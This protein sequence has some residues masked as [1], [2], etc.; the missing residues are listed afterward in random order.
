MDSSKFDL[1]KLRSLRA[2]NG[3]WCTSAAQQVL[4]NS[5]VRSAEVTHRFHLSSHPPVVVIGNGRAVILLV[6]TCVFTILIAIM[7]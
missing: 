4:S 1:A 3:A 5:P 7:I 2:N 6:F